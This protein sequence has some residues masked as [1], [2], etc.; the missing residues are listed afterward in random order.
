MYIHTLGRNMYVYT[1][2]HT[3]GGMEQDCGGLDTVGRRGAVVATDGSLV[4]SSD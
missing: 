1:Y 4:S 3:W 2:I